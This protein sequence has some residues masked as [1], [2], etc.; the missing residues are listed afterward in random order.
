VAIY[1]IQKDRQG[2]ISVMLEMHYGRQKE[3]TAPWMVQGSEALR[4]EV[5][6][7]AALARETR[8]SRKTNTLAYVS[9]G[10]EK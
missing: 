10:R 9:R 7:L 3:Y 6:N 1:H 2:N 5:Q 8:N 4:S